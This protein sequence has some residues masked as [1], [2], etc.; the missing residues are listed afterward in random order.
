MV[1][2][3]KESEI[4]Q[5]QGEKSNMKAYSEDL[6]VKVL[7]AVDQG[8]PREEIVKLVGVSQATIKRYVKQ[9]RHSFSGHQEQRRD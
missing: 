8:H 5:K 3:R 7:R 4:G 2:S 9:R 1:N 6:R